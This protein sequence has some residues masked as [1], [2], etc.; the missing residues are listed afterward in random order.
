MSY[1]YLE[2]GV[3]MCYGFHGDRFF[4]MS[5]GYLCNGGVCMLYGLLDDRFSDMSHNYLVMGCRFA[6]RCLV[7]GVSVCYELSISG[8][9]MICK[10]PL[11]E[12]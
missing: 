11:Y 3:G 12:G 7:A 2:G 8:S 6:L 5:H 1:D 10:P 9:G 4:Y